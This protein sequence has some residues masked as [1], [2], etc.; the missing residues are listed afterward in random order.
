ME[1]RADEPMAGRRARISDVAAAAGVSV[2]T[3]S[4]ALSGARTVN[5]QTRER[6]L[7]V[8]ESLG[9][10]PDRIASGLRRKR[11]GVVGFVGDHVATTPYAGHMIAGARVAGL[12]HDVLLLVA[13]SEGDAAEEQSL[14]HRLVAQRI[15]GLLIARMY[16]QRVMRP[17]VP[18]GLPVVLVDAAPE[19][20]WSVDAVVPDEV[21]ITR[22]ACDRLLTAGHVRIAYAGTSDDSR[23]ARARLVGIRTA[24]GDAGVPLPKAR[25]AAVTSDAAGGRDAGAALLDR[26]DPPTAVVCFND[27]I[28]MGVMQAAARRGLRVPDDLSVMGVDDLRPVA[29]ALDPG[30]TTV[31]LPHAAMGGWGMQRLLARIEGTLADP[32]KGLQLMPGWLVERGT[33]APPPA[34]APRS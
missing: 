9:Y 14:I 1:E 13:E 5:P 21:Q 25:I 23:A 19:A 16:H 34:P 33:V 28:A 26:A 12:E 20:G 22:L 24:L 8:A 15:D 32:P 4:H 10:A 3:V 30:L 11:T 27:Q 31:A 17:V 2:T 6:I 7:S 18:A 29:D